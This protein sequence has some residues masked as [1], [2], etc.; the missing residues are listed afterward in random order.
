MT[1]PSAIQS[2]FTQFQNLLR[3]MFQFDGNDLDFGLFKILRLKHAFIDQFIAL[4]EALFARPDSQARLRPG[5]TPRLAARALHAQILGLFTDWTRDPQLFD[6]L[7]DTR[8]LI[9]A[10]MQGLLRD[11]NPPAR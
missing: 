8:A 7:S 4:V 5:L 3:E 10:L 11:W 9:D 2:P 1:T 6:P